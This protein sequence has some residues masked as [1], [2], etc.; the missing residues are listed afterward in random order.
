MGVTK[1]VVEE[2]G[3]LDQGID[4]KPPA[5]K[6]CEEGPFSTRFPAIRNE[7]GK[8]CTPEALEAHIKLVR[9][10]RTNLRERGV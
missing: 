8:K 7:L 2:V 1:R 9:L 10:Q 6:L 4:E 5:L 3:P